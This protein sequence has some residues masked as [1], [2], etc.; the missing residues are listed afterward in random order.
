MFLAADLSCLAD[1]S[2][3]FVESF[4]PLNAT[5][6]SL[7]SSRFALAAAMSPPLPPEIS[8]TEFINDT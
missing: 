8:L 3:C 5:I 6:A 4:L 1:A 2:N 7:I